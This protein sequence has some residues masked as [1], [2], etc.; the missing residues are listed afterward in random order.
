MSARLN[1]DLNTYLCFLCYAYCSLAKLRKQN[2][3]HYFWLW[4]KP[5]MLTIPHHLRNWPVPV[6]IDKEQCSLRDT[7]T[8]NQLKPG[9]QTFCIFVA[10][11]IRKRRGKGEGREGVCDRRNF[12]KRLHW[13]MRNN[14]CEAFAKYVTSFFWLWNPDLFALKKIQS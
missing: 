7:E 14:Q 5:L 10:G 8:V 4:W 9:K 13:Q 11:S 1:K 6:C 2:S 3:I 12:A